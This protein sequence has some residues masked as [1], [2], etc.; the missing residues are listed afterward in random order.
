M[1]DTVGSLG[2]SS[3]PATGVPFTNQPNEVGVAAFTGGVNVT[4]GGTTEDVGAS[5]PAP[6]R[7]RIG[8]MFVGSEP[9]VPPAPPP[10]PSIGGGV[11]SASA[12]QTCVVPSEL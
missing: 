12:V 7:F 8:L 1:N 9:I 10:G 3:P 4:I 6:Y 11:G 2:G 5:A